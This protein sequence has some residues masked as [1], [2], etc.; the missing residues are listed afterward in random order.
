MKKLS[1]LVA[2]FPC[3]TLEEFP[4]HHKSDDAQGLLASWTVLWHPQLIGA[5]GQIPDWHRADLTAP[6]EQEQAEFFTE[7][8]QQ[9]ISQQYYSDDQYSDNDEPVGCSGSGKAELESSDFDQEQF[10]RMWT[11]A[12]IAIPTVCKSRVRNGFAAAVI[13]RGATVVSGLNSRTEILDQLKIDAPEKMEGGA[14]CQLVEDFFSLGYCLLQV[15]LMTNQLRYSSNLCMDTMNERAVEAATAFVDGDLEST[16]AWLGSCFDLL[17]E[18]K[19]NYY[20]VA[21]DLIDIVLLAPSTLGKSLQK[22]LAEEHSQNFLM[23]GAIST[24]LQ[25]KSPSLLTQIKDGIESGKHS[26]VGGTEQ[27]LPNSLLSIESLLNQFSLARDSYSASI[28]NESRVFMRQRFGLGPA[29]PNLLDGLNFAGAVHVTLDDGKFPNGSMGNIKWGGHDGASIM[30]LTEVPLD[31]SRDDQFLDLALKIGRQ[32][33]SAHVATLVFAHWPNQT[34]D[35]FRDVAN[36]VRYGNILGEFKNLDSFFDAVHDPGYCDKLEADDYESPFLKQSLAASSSR[37]IST[38]T[39]YWRLM[40]EVNALRSLLLLVSAKSSIT[41]NESSEFQFN[42]C[43]NQLNALQARIELQTAEWASPPEWESIVKKLG[44]LKHALLAG[45]GGASETESDSSE[46]DSGSMLINLHSSPKRVHWQ[47]ATMKS[48]SVKKFPPV[49]VAQCRDGRGHWV[50]DLPAMGSLDL[51]SIQVQQDSLRAEPFVDDGHTLRNEFFEVVIDSETGGIR[52]VNFHGKRGNL[53]G[54]QLAIRIPGERDPLRP[55]FLQSRY[56]SMVCEKL[57]T[58]RL[59]K[60]A[61]EIKTTGK[62]VDDEHELAKFEQTVTVVRG[63]RIVELELNIDLTGSL[64]GTT[65]NY[66]CVRTAWQNESAQVFAGMQG[67]LQPIYRPWLDAPQLIDIVD[68]AYKLSLFTNGLP[69]HRRTS[70]RMMDSIL[71][72]G[73]ETQRS[74]KLGM[75][76][77]VPNSMSACVGRMTPLMNLRVAANPLN[78]LWYFHVANRNVVATW[79][80]AILNDDC[81]CVGLRVRLMETEGRAGRLKLHCFREMETVDRENFLNGFVRHVVQNERDAEVESDQTNAIDR[82]IVEVD[83]T[84]FEFFQIKLMFSEAS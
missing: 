54:Q 52:A 64:N 74:F 20:P 83:F 42:E 46:A 33:D 82:S 35:S 29:M 11:D 65:G 75:G 68:D 41:Q 44:Q 12:L 31:A 63:S 10:D 72:V 45:Y 55:D 69:Y 57:E 16:R 17:A 80:D 49:H 2:L 9:Y 48:G 7:S 38:F 59:S 32:M 58:N 40:S 8:E 47:S 73:N 70:R 84:A 14:H 28:G 37:P 67:F 30:A 77:N 56:T 27:E 61:A 60:V 3:R 5:A 71:I 43:R 62:L 25:E 76:I 36:S 6:D 66:L 19:N 1:R 13:E 15:Q 4:T 22:Q 51:D 18:E 50:V 21:P 81:R 53:V 26:L 79:W 34:C 78:P 24:A 39:N 23:T